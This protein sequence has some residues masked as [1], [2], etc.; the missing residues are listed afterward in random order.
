MSRDRG[1]AESASILEGFS[2]QMRAIAEVSRQRVQLTGSASAAGGRVT[3]TVN[4]DC[5]VIA[6]RFASDADELS[7]EEIGKAVTSAA[8]NAAADVRRKTEELL[9][10][11]N[12]QRAKMPR[13]SELFDGMPDLQA[14]APTPPPVSLAPPNA[15]ER[16][17]QRV[18][19]APEFSDAVDYEDWQSAQ[20]GGGP[21]SRGW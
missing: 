20:D 17:A 19:P 13:L 15:R 2:R 12:D 9:R 14:E 7:L 11:I 4:A 5:V 8:Q 21:T 10:P 16:L 1:E 3:V 6:T 18:E